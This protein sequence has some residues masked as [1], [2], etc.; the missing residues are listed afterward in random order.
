MDNKCPN[1][2]GSIENGK[3][4]YCGTSV[5]TAPAYVRAPEPIYSQSYVQPQPVII[6]NF[7]PQQSTKS[8]TT[9]LLLAIFLGYFGIHRF[10]VGKV[11]TGLIWLFTWGIFGVGWIVDIIMIATG[12][13]NDSHGLSLK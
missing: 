11:G 6:N 1:C 10:Y 2:G 12:S 8:K 4:I 9:T 13:F 5:A 3:C 7:A